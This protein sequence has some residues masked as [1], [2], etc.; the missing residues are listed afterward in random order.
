[1]PENYK[2]K[3]QYFEKIECWVIYWLQWLRI[4]NLQIVFFGY[5]YNKNFAFC[6]YGAYEM[7]KSRRK[8]NTSQLRKRSNM[9]IIVETILYYCSFKW[10]DLV[11]CTGEKIFCVV[12]SYPFQELWFAVSEQNCY[13]GWQRWFGQQD[14][15]WF[16]H[17]YIRVFSRYE[18]VLP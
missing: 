8:L 11:L 12:S 15:V 7:A 6:I 18:F 4:N 17:L 13:G 16:L 14:M 9:K 5:L 3:G 10:Q 1:M 2:G